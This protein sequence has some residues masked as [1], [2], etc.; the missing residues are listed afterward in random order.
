MSEELDETQA[1]AINRAFR[2][3]LV[4][5]P[6]RNRMTTNNGTDNYTSGGARAVTVDWDKWNYME[7]NW[8]GK[9]WVRIKR[10]FK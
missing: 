7:A 3:S 10:L 8:I 1:Y 9:L 4:R 5:E 6:N 2:E